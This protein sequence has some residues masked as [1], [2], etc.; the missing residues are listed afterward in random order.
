MADIGRQYRNTVFIQPLIDA[1]HIVPLKIELVIA[2]DK[3]VI[4]DLLQA[5]RHGGRIIR[6]AGTA[7]LELYL[8]YLSTLEQIAI[9]NK[10][11]VFRP[12]FLSDLP[13]R[14]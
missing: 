2:R 3:G 8:G 5:D 9:V 10:E 13:D 7:L 1:A 11:Y 6:N 14:R 12:V 4:A